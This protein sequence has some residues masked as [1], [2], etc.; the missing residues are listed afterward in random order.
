M[1]LGNE[2]EEKYCLEVIEVNFESL[3]K[4]CIEKSFL[5]LK[6]LFMGICLKE[7]CDKLEIVDEINYF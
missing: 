3:V 6:F 1:S 7:S 4:E 5:L 2:V